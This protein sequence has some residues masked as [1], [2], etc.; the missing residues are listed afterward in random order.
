VRWKGPALLHVRDN[1]WEQATLLQKQ[2][3]LRTVQILPPD[4]HKGFAE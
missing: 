4:E 3:F 2:Q 1:T